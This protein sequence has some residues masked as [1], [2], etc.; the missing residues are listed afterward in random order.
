MAR[1]PQQQ[2]PLEDSP[3]SG[4]GHVDFDQNGTPTKSWFRVM[5]QLGNQVEREPMLN[6]QQDR[7][8]HYS[9]NDRLQGWRP[10]IS[11]GLKLPQPY[12]APDASAETGPDRQQE[13]T[14]PAPWIDQEN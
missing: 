3:N 5:H 7:D 1:S 10:D 12:D 13:P 6:S 8:H 4:L 2:R 14:M 9:N 11:S